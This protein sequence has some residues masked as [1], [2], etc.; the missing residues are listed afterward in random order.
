MNGTNTLARLLYYLKKQN[1]DFK[2]YLEEYYN[3]GKDSKAHRKE[4][5]DNPSTILVRYEEFLD[6][7]P[8][9]SDPD[10]DSDLK[11]RKRNKIK[12]CE[13]TQP[14]TFFYNIGTHQFLPSLVLCLRK[15]L[16]TLGTIQ[17]LNTATDSNN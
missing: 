5:N 17:E 1:P 16:L 4:L 11:K 10:E 2:K 14:R 8:P 12:T 6:T 9:I 13:A 15:Q 3:K 7:N